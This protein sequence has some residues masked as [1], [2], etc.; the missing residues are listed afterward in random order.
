M[1]QIVRILQKWEILPAQITSPF[2][3]LIAWVV[4]PAL[5][6]SQQADTI[7]WAPIG[8][9]WH[10]QVQFEPLD[11]EYVGSIKVTSVGDTVVV[12]KTY[13]KLAIDGWIYN[14]ILVRQ[15]GKQLLRLDDSVDVVLFDFGLEIGD[16]LVLRTFKAGFNCPGDLNL[17]LDSLYVVQVN[18]QSRSKQVFRGGGGIDLADSDFGPELAVIRNQFYEKNNTI[19]NSRNS[20]L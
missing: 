6:L 15:E 5:L 12:D 11:P 13:R 2:G 20:F 10:Y 19:I 1:T 7:Q 3:F 16:T 8:A 14:H 17:V 4:A 9:H 18:G